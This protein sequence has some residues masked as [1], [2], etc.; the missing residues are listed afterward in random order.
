MYSAFGGY[1]QMKKNYDYP[2]VVRD[3][4]FENNE[5]ITEYETDDGLIMVLFTWKKK[6]YYYKTTDYN[7]LYKEIYN[8]I[9]KI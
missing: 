9:K 5:K 2:N 4:I 1:C 6:K 8:F 3:L 7:K